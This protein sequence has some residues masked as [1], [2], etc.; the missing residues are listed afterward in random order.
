MPILWLGETRDF[1][2]AERARRDGLLAVGGGLEP[3]RLLRAYGRGIFPWY[4][5]GQPILWWSPAPRFV[6]FPAEFHAGST[7]KKVLR[8]GDFRFRFD[9]AFGAV[10]ECCAR[11]RPGQPGTWIT[12]DMRAAYLRLH[13]LGY[14][15]SLEAWI[16]GDLAGG[17][18]GVVLGNCFFAESMFHCANN[19]SKA[20]L[21][22]LAATLHRMEFVL[23]D[24]QVP[25]PHLAAWGARSI[26]RRRYLELVRQG[27]RFRTLRGS[28]AGIELAHV[29]IPG[30]SAPGM[31]RA[32]VTRNR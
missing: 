13:R 12:P 16:G 19:A 14:A 26:P 22:V 15:H 8:R 6:L 31:M 27:L 18:Y 21:A 30:Q 7:L 10:V 2:P 3:R 17:V 5:E 32:I 9:H 1:P 24:C 4:E 11:P 29:G 28:W 20:A 25:T 23:I